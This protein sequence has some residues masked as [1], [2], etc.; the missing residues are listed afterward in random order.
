MLQGEPVA[1]AIRDHQ[2]AVRDWQYARLSSELHRW[3]EIFDLEFK[4]HLTSYPITMFAPLRNAYATYYAGR[5]E[6]GTRDNITFNTNELTRDPAL[7]L[8]TLC[9][10]LIHLWQRYL[11]TPSKRNYHNEE[12]RSKALEC[13][14]IVSP[15]GC[16]CGHTQVFTNVLLKYGIQLEPLAAEMRLW[17]SSKRDIKM[18]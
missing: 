1:R 7:I 2:T 3:V 11:G 4:L 9:H 5:S 10:E 15:E 6:L 16:T 17:G 18:K 8:R 14:L 13:G 12:F